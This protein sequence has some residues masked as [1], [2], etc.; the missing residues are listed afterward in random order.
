[1][2]IESWNRQNFEDSENLSLI[3]WFISSQYSKDFIR[4]V[5]QNK[6]KWAKQ[7]L[8]D[9]IWNV[10]QSFRSGY[11]LGV[12]AQDSIEFIHNVGVYLNECKVLN[13]ELLDYKIYFLVRESLMKKQWVPSNYIDEDSLQINFLKKISK[14]PLK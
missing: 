11:N 13:K 8:E 5:V 1:M 9:H 7:I 4:E 2:D 6:P 12:F 3:H 14:N 10:I